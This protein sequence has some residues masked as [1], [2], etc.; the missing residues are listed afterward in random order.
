[1]QLYDWMRDTTPE[2]EKEMKEHHWD[3]EEV[4]FGPVKERYKQPS[5]V[6]KPAEHA[7][8]RRRATVACLRQCLASAARAARAGAPPVHHMLIRSPMRRLCSAKHKTGTRG[9]WRSLCLPMVHGVPSG[10]WCR[11]PAGQRIACRKRLQCARLL[12]RLAERAR[13]PGRQLRSAGYGKC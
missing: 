1:M 2:E 5:L 10:R 12:Q 13:G 8:V 4:T 9:P 7:Q 11:G 6:N 3:L